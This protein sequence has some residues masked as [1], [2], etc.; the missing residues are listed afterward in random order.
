MAPA[1]HQLPRFGRA[2]VRRPVRLQS[3]DLFTPVGRRN[4]MRTGTEASVDLAK[5]GI[6]KPAFSKLPVARIRRNTIEKIVARNT[7]HSFEM[8][9]YLPKPVL[10]FGELFW[11]LNIICDIRSHQLT[12][13]DFNDHLSAFRHADA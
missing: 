9:D 13:L 6:S 12:V 1:I 2:C 7:G 8:F 3:Q 11:I 5:P 4:P 10:D